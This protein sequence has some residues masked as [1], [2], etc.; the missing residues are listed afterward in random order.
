MLKQQVDILK[1]QL[2]LAHE[3]EI[4]QREQLATK[5]NQIEAIQRL[6]EAP[7]PHMTTFTDQKFNEDIA[8]NPRSEPEQNYDGLTTPDQ[9]ENKRI[10]VPEH[11]EPEPPKR[12]FLSRFFLPNG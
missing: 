10:P 12:G 2:E 7:K 6:L 4:F 5:D 1:K 8:T 9:K 3:R 11:V